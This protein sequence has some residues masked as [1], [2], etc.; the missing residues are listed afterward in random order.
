MPVPTDQTGTSSTS[1]AAGVVDI[2]QCVATARFIYVLE[3]NSSA[4]DM[5]SLIRWAY[6]SS[7]RMLHI[8][9]YEH[10]LA[11]VLEPEPLKPLWLK[12][13]DFET[14]DQKWVSQINA[15]TAR[16][17]RDEAQ[18]D[19]LSWSETCKEVVRWN[20]ASWPIIVG[21]WNAGITRPSSCP[22]WNI[23]NPHYLAEARRLMNFVLAG[24]DVIIGT[25]PAIVELAGHAS[26]N[27]W[28]TIVGDGTDR[29][30][31]EK[32]IRVLW[33]HLPCRT[34]I[35]LG[36]IT[37]ATTVPRKRRPSCTHKAD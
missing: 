26:F 17:H 4:D 31:R 20:P 37:S 13:K 16:R 9:M 22:S 14:E 32:T 33:D 3:E 28:S 25:A 11:N 35:S 30:L 12:K 36:D 29:I 10:E 6:S 24:A 15:I 34:N 18:S 19:P 27:P 21:A 1:G 5:I 23:K 2:S 8:Y 7:G